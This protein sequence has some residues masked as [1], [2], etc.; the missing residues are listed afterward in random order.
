MKILYVNWHTTGAAE[1]YGLKE[2]D[3]AISENIVPCW[4]CRY[5]KRGDYHMCESAHLQVVC[6]QRGT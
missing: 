4:E 2:G 3:M 5:C 1:K 6:H